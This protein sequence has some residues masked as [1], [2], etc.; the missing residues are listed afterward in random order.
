MYFERCF[1]TIHNI[2]NSNSDSLNLLIISLLTLFI[3]QLKVSGVMIFTFYIFYIVYLF[4]NKMLK[5][6]GI[7]ETLVPII[8]GFIWIL[9]SI[10]TTGCLIFPLAIIWIYTLVK[11]KIKIS[12]I[13]LDLFYGLTIIFFLTFQ[14]FYKIIIRIIILYFTNQLKI[15]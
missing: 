8:F 7:K 12:S 14:L 6:I 3:Y 13:A 5:E 2:K 11:K 9:K 15:Y 1:N 4:R 10:L